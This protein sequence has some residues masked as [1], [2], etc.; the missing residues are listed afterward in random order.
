[1]RRRYLYLCMFLCLFVCVCVYVYATITN[2][3]Q[4]RT[5]SFTLSIPHMN[6]HV[7][8]CMFDPSRMMSYKH[9][10]SSPTF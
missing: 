7:V 5:L 4:E 10:F 2:E 8:A 3:E 6:G 1:M 9:T